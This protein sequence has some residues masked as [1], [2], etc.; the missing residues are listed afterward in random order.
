VKVEDLR[1]LVVTDWLLNERA[2]AKSGVTRW[3][4]PLRV[5]SGVRVSDITTAVMEDYKAKRL[6]EGAARSTINSEIGF[7]RR[8]FKLAMEQDL[9][10]KMPKIK[11]L[12]T[13]NVREGF[14]DPSDFGQLV[15]TLE[16]LD[17]PVA[18][19]IRFLY[20]LGWRR[21][22]VV[23]L[24]WSEVDI[25]AGTIRLPARRTKNRTPKTV[26][27]SAHLRDILTRRHSLKNGPWVF[28]RA[29]RAIRDFRGTWRRAVKALG[30]PGLLVHDLRRSFARNAV[31]AGLPVKLIMEIAGW[32][33]MSVFLRYAIV[34]E[35]LIARG[36]D[37][38]SKFTLREQGRKRKT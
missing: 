36:L 37:R 30:R 5:L 21:G 19:V 34:D 33:T 35:R 12:R 14:L 28:H 29:G 13:S 16:V 31:E 3:R 6:A 32:K 4:H 1:S 9:L 38:V 18:D 27:I 2:A 26:R 11:Q 8:G 20:L 24:L 17:P 15:R 7:V 23:G 10:S 22:E 25:A